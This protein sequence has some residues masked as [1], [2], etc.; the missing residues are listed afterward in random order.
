MPVQFTVK[1]KTPA[2]GSATRKFANDKGV[3]EQVKEEIESALG[4]VAIGAIQGADSLTNHQKIT[5]AAT[6]FQRAVAR[7]PLDEDYLRND[8]KGGHKADNDV[9]RDDWYLSYGGRKFYARDFPGCFES[10]NDMGAIARIASA[11]ESGIRRVGNIRTFTVGNDNPRFSQLEYGEYVVSEE[12]V[13]GTGKRPHG[14]V[15]GFSVQAPQGM[16]RITETEIYGM[17][18]QVSKPGLLAKAERLLENGSSGSKVRGKGKKRTSRS[19]EKAAYGYLKRNGRLKDA[20][21]K[22]FL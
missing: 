15:G 1:T 12:G 14:V 21:I 9:V 13:K 5:L 8:G 3:S 7:T 4:K 2:R 11:V 16:L 6:F 18:R 22:R 10:V 20:D 17:A 19:Q